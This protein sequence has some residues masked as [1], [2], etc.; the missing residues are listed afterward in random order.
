MAW[1]ELHQQVPTHPKTKR[2]TRAL[3]LEV[4]KDIP[5]VVG[6][7][8]MFWLWCIDYAIDGSLGKMTAQDIADAA[9]W[10]DDPKAFVDAMRQVEFIDTIDGT[11]YVHDWDDYIGKLIDFREKEKARN[12][13]K[14]RRHRERI[15]QQAAQELQ[16]HEDVPPQDAAPDV[17]PG[18]DSEWLKVVKCY[19]KN[20]GLIPHG[21]SGEILVSFYED[22]GADVVCKAIEV[23]NTASAN[24]PW[25]YLQAVLNRWVE[26]KIDTVEKAEAYIKDLDRQFEEHKRRVGGQR[27]EAGEPPAIKGKFY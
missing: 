7:L 10:T 4:P 14:Q 15:K 26:R 2:L 5:Q 25:K 23:T 17:V 21:T 18:I 11:D 9:G 8:C 22:L 24:N 13:E 20:I 16:P 12:R 3:G 27:S 6:H 19:E 1:I